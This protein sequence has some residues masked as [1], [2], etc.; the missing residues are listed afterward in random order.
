M[1]E[2]KQNR[3]IYFFKEPKNQIKRQ[4]VN[5]PFCLVYITATVY[6]NE[7]KPEV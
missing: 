2:I 6:Y 5:V 1:K 7:C 4:E 3:P